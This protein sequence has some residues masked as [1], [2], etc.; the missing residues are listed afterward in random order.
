MI[1]PPSAV[2][3]WKSF[4][5]RFVPCGRGVR[6]HSAR[7]RCSMSC[8][9]SCQ[10]LGKSSEEK[11]E[12][13]LQLPS[14]E[15]RSFVAHECPVPP[16]GSGSPSPC[17]GCLDPWL[18][19]PV[20]QRT[21]VSS[22][23]AEPSEAILEV[24]VLRLIRCRKPKEAERNTLLDFGSKKLPDMWLQLAQAKHSGQNFL[25]SLNTS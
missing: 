20:C 24:G 16:G 6:Q 4:V 25:D 17:R 10:I 5:R 7:S 15:G 19:P 9:K 11:G 3:W 13:F 23:S 18:L 14:V 1:F 21:L 12:R 2:L 22:S 8:G